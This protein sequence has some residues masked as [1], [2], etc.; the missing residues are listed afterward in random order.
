[1][2]WSKYKDTFKLMK[3][4]LTQ[5]SQWYSLNGCRAKQILKTN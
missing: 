4:E 3:V 2:T 1:M 5:A